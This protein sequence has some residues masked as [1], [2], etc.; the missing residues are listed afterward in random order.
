MKLKSGRVLDDV[1][2][3]KLA[4]EAERGYD[5]SMA[6]R[7][8]LRPGRPARGEPAGE[9]PRVTSRI[10][11]KV[12]SAA[13]QR[14]KEEGLT[15]SEVVRTL[16]TAYASGRSL[17]KVVSRHAV[18]AGQPSDS[19]RPAI[20]MDDHGRRRTPRGPRKARSYSPWT[21]TDDD[22]RFRVCL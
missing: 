7:V 18:L 2:I 19:N 12:Y 3:E 11:E 13:K 10:P 15:V 5:L 4:S 20:R 17:R 22:R 1:L 6:R 14:A 9:S 21:T 16:L 8:A